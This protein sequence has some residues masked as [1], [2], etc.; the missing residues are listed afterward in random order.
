[1]LEGTQVGIEKCAFH[2]KFEITGSLE[3]EGLQEID[4][5]CLVIRENVLLTLGS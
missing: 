3:S 5:C 2:W 1:M 4:Q